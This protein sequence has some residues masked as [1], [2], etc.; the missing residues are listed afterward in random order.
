MHNRKVA[1]QQRVQANILG[2]KKDRDQ[3]VQAFKSRH[4]DSA[5][6]MSAKMLKKAACKI[7]STKLLEKVFQRCRKQAGKL[8]ILC[9]SIKRMVITNQSD[10]GNC[11][12]Y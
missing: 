3:I 4:P 10:F 9:R 1:I 12:H 7:T 2:N 8:L 6:N 11:L 5:Q